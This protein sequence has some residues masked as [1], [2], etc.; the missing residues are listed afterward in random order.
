MLSGLPVS[1]LMKAINQND[2]STEL[3]WKELERRAKGEELN[4]SALITLGGLS[5]LTSHTSR[6]DFTTALYCYNRVLE[7][8]KPTSTSY[9]I[10]KNALARV[11]NKLHA[12]ANSSPIDKSAEK[13]LCEYYLPKLD[14]PDPRA[15][16]YAA[17]AYE[18]GYG[19][20]KH[21]FKALHYYLD[22]QKAALAS[23]VNP[24]IW[25]LV[26]KRVDALINMQDEKPT[27]SPSLETD[28]SFDAQVIIDFGGTPSELGF[29]PSIGALALAYKWNSTRPE[30]CGLLSGPEFLA[31][32]ETAKES[33]FHG[34]EKQRVRFY[35]VG[36]SY[37]SSSN[38]HYDNEEPTHIA[39]IAAKLSKFISSQSAEVNLVSCFG[40]AQYDMED[41]DDS[42]G[43]TLHSLLYNY[44]K[45]DIPVI[46]RSS[47]V[48]FDHFGKKTVALSEFSHGNSV[49]E[50]KDEQDFDALK[51][52]GIQNSASI[53]NIEKQFMESKGI[54]PG[55]ETK[56]TFGKNLPGSK[57]RFFMNNGT[58]CVA[59][60]S[61]EKVKTKGFKK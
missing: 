28:S 27:V 29:V 26:K 43:Q 37:P 30:K 15:K 19:G 49:R 48:I 46:A 10:A 18:L 20:E 22:A 9:V 16:Y 38:L 21:T 12:L 50:L 23:P 59:D 41:A 57:V 2:T 1:E 25:N 4:P 3:A 47:L 52:T 53:N 31:Q 42:L 35:I 55:E 24:D 14:S 8:E 56:K 61:K 45:R 39:I 6:Q 44:S 11:L 60:V 13:I 17:L 58:Q 36:H 54:K 40:A 7:E 51:L 34:N 33:V 32:N 5:S